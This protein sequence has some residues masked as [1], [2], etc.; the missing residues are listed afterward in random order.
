MARTSRLGGSGPDDQDA[1]AVLAILAALAASSGADETI[2]PL[3]SVWGGHAHRLGV[4]SVSATGWWA[5]G[6]PRGDN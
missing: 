6:L 4:R 3:R 5:S 2:P 1:A